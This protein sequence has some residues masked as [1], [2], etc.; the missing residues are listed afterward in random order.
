MFSNCYENRRDFGVNLPAIA[1]KYPET[2][3][4]DNIIY[5]KK[6]NLFLLFIGMKCGIMFFKRLHH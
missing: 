1:Q 5:P 3:R 2:R 6:G 4:Y